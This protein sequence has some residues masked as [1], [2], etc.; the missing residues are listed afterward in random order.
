MVDMF[1]KKSAIKSQLASK[2][3]Q[4][5]N[6]TR[7]KLQK[8]NQIP[9]TLPRMLILAYRIQHYIRLPNLCLHSRFSHYKISGWT[10]ILLQGYL[11]LN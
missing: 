4:K 5:Q 7:T 10:S 9:K 1:G 2:Q 3:E 8:E 6:K 11:Y